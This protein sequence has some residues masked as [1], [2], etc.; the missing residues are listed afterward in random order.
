ML[1][2]NLLKMNKQCNLQI[3]AGIVTVHDFHCIFAHFH[4]NL[5]KLVKLAL[6]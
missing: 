6:G 1:P 4:S 2:K 5:P 3:E